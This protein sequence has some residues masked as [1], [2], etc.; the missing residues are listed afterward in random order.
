MQKGSIFDASLVRLRSFVGIISILLKILM[1]IRRKVAQG[2]S[3]FCN[4]RM[5]F[6]FVMCTFGLVFK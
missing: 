2:R 1:S 3:D 6:V 5:L 4:E